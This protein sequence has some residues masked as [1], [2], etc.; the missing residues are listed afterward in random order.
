MSQEIELNPID[1]ITVGT[2][3]PKGR[4][5]F[6]LQAGSGD[7]LVTLTLEKEQARALGEAVTELL[8]DLNERQPD[9]SG[10]NVNISL[11]NMN[12]RDPIEPMF[13]I[14]QIGLGYDDVRNMVVIVSQELPLSDDTQDV[15]TRQPRIA[16]FWGERRHFRALSQHAD[17]IVNKGRADPKSNGRV[18]Y[19]WT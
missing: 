4:R 1:F 10:E 16:R 2:V 15:E 12:L 6:H 7:Q 8:N 9:P 5:I 19:Y 13:R 18:I 11:L 17:K 3:G 14:A